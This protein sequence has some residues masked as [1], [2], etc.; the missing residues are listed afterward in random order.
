[1]MTRELERKLN[2][3]TEMAKQARHEF[4]TLEHILLSISSSPSLVETLE[5]CGVNVQVLRKSLRESLKKIPAI[6][7]EQLD[8]YGGFD[9]WN[10]EFTL[11]CHRLFQR[12]ALQV[13]SSGRNQITE[14]TLLIALFYEQDSHAVYSLAQQGLNQFDLINYVSHGIT[15]DV[16]DLD[17]ASHPAA[18]DEAERDDKRKSPLEE[19]CV[20]LNEK[21]KAGRIDP[22]I[23]RDQVLERV[24]QILLR[25]TKNNPLLIGEPG[26]GKT[27]IAEGLAA[28][29]VAGEV[30]ERLKDA[31]IYSLDLGSLLAGTKF[32]GDFEGRLKGVIKDIKKRPNAVLFIDEIH[33]LVGAGATSGGSMDASN[34]LKPAL[35]SG[36][37]S[38]IGSTTHTEYRQY[39]EKDRALNRRF[40]RVDVSEPSAADCLEILKGL[41]A[42]YESFHNVRYTDEALKACVDLSLKHMHGKL[43]PDKAI[44]LMDEAGAHL[45]LKNSA[46][47]TIRVD[48]NEIENTVA[49]MTGLPAAAVSSNERTQLKDL[50]RKLKAVIFGQDEAIEKLA[51]AIKLSRSGLAR[52][53]KPIGSFLFTGPTGVGKTEVCK[54]LAQILGVHFHRFDMSEYM[55]KHAVARL[56]G[57]P[58]GYVG[59]EEGGL[60]TEAVNKQPYAVLLLD[61]IEKAHP[62]INN[63]LLQVMDA[64]RMTDAHGRIA[65]FKNVILVMTSNAGAQEVA[66]GS[67]GLLE[68]NRSSLSL[69]AIKRQFSPEFLN[70]LDAIVGFRDLPEDVVLKIVGKFVDEVRMSLL[71]KKVVLQT[72]PDVLKWLLKKGYDKVYGARPLARAVDE[73]LK[74][75]LVDELLFGRLADGGLVS[76]EVENNALRFHFSTGADSGPRSKVRVTT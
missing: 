66:K 11:A 53:N 75:P 51:S 33:T 74:K 42:S 56:I 18:V 52:P 63:A 67:I 22:L 27:A 65:D 30:P 47:E 61:E 28:K 41:R 72:T 13:K 70:R 26:V 49:R 71:E 14:E 68:D 58:P 69:E 55:E 36:E 48:V 73:H 6:P 54:Q 40:Q 12:A 1:M 32:R 19:F 60:L 38:C 64:G 17:M 21:A 29:I 76:V 44:D 50:D 43:L 57:A 23:G 7:D 39:F 4:V 3:A 2:E 15:K 35:A 8:S 31:V 16:D 37:I 46:A 9:A 10:P 25:R 62:D 5:A 59:Y 45:R 34:L 24:A 20:N